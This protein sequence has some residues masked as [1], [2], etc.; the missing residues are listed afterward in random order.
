MLLRA[1]DQHTQT[2]AGADTAKWQSFSI[3]NVL[4]D[5]LHDDEEEDLD[6][7]VDAG[8][9]TEAAERVPMPPGDGLFPADLSPGA[10]S[11][12]SGAGD[13][14][15]TGRPDDTADVQK[16]LNSS[17]LRCADELREFGRW[18]AFQTSPHVIITSS[19]HPA[20]LNNQYNNHGTSVA[21]I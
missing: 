16:T 21:Y 18:T 11:S 17:S 5:T 13:V 7:V 20:A 15:F 10:A 1:G 8:R 14:D 6:V 12:S 4:G 3:R 9:R 2:G 19:Q